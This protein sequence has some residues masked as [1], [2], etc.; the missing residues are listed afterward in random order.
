MTRPRCQAV[1][2]LAAV[3]GTEADWLAGTVN[4]RPWP[5][6]GLELGECAHG[7]GT[8]LSRVVDRDAYSRACGDEAVSA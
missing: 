5:E 2:H 3:N 7:C 8:T 1:A 6:F 4:R